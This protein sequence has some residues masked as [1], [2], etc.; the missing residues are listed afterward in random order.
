MSTPRD[1]LK[2]SDK[3]FTVYYY[4]LS[5]SKFNQYEENHRYVYKNSFNVQ[6]ACKML[7][8]SKSTF[9]KAIDALCDCDF[10]QKF[11]DYYLLYAPHCKYADINL[12]ILSGLLMFRKFT[13]VDLIRTYL[14]LL[15]LYEIDS[16]E[17]K[18]FSRKSLLEVLGLSTKRKENYLIMEIYLSLLQEWKLIKITEKK[19]TNNFTT[20]TLYSLDKVSHKSDYIE[21]LSS[22]I[23][24][25]IKLD[26]YCDGIT[27][28]IRNKL[29]KIIALR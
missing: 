29:I 14:V 16:R 24:C 18:T 19:I 1:D 10:V 20:Y 22:R 23:D 25:E 17:V 21:N 26:G 8:L 27:D 7:G 2:L 15:N 28:E 6:K 13:G 3:Q 11:K 4:L 9:Y 12:S 5:I